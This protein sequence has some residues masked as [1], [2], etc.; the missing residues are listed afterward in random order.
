MTRRICRLFLLVLLVFFVS[1]AFAAPQKNGFERQRDRLR[2]K[3]GTTGRAVLLSGTGAGITDKTFYY[4]TGIR[5]VHPYLIVLPVPGG[6]YL[7]LNSTRNRTK[8]RRLAKVSGITNILPKRE[9]RRIFGLE[10]WRNNVYYP[11]GS[12][13]RGLMDR[14]MGENP[15]YTLR[16]VSPILLRM[17]MVKTPEELETLQKA[18]DVTASGLLEAIRQARPGMYEYDLQ[19]II[20]STFRLLGAPRCSFDSIIGSGPNSTIIHWM[21]NTRQTQPG[22]LVVMDV[23]AEYRQYAGDITRTIPISGT[24]TS[25][26]RQVYE[27]VL[28]AQQRA[29]QVCG[30]GATL[31]EIDQAARTTI[32]DAGYGAYFPHFTS[33]SLGLDVHDPWPG[34]YTRL[35]RG[36]VITIEPGIYITAEQLGVRIEDDV[37]VTQDGCRVLSS[38]VPK[39][40]DAI[41]QLMRQSR[42]HR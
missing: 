40:P 14:L 34:Q 42:L 18:A 9:F 3:I 33:H 39:D 38:L 15:N 31:Y 27:I 35:A 22:D 4:L 8:V 2:K 1:A 23:G 41:E 7:F 21:A 29:M 36:A 26:Q 19:H 32:T 25:R 6:D 10:P 5:E 24:F 12:F 20:E 16:D 17:R 28:A 30:P 37:V 11:E 13:G